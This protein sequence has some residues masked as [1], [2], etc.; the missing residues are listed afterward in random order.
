MI[1]NDIIIRFATYDIYLCYSEDDIII[2]ILFKIS[3]F[4]N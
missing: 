3:K 1:I 2:F 4:Y